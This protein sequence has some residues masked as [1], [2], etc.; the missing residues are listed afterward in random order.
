MPPK[1]RECV[2]AYGYAIVRACLDVKVSDPNRI[3]ALVNSIWEGARQP[4]QRRERGGALEWLLIQA[5]AEISVATL[6][7]VLANNDLAI[8]PL[9]PTNGMIDASMATVSNFDLRVT[10]TEKHRM[11]LKA[12]IAAG[13]AEVRPQRAI[14]GRVQLPSGSSVVSSTSRG[15]G[16][17]MIAQS[18]PG[19]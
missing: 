12:A 2:H 18:L 7:R 17:T 15:K 11:R 8:V 13:M 9:K 19:T 16:R 4:A 6:M 10:K 14:G 1:L 5:G 3:H